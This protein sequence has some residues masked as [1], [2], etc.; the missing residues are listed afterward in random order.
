MATKNCELAT[1]FLVLSRQKRQDFIFNFEP[2]DG[3]L[4]FVQN[5][6]YYYINHI[7]AGKLWLCAMLYVL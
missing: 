6:H 1:K 3:V 2:C 5:I 7:Y 4:S